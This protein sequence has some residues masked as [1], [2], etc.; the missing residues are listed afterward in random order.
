MIDLNNM[1][2]LIPKKS[3]NAIKR[4]TLKEGE[5]RYNIR[6]SGPEKKLLIKAA[7]IANFPDVAKFVREAC[8]KEAHRIIDEDNNIIAVTGDYMGENC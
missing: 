6:F 5:G 2:P 7:R 4:A 1:K 3:E 8:V